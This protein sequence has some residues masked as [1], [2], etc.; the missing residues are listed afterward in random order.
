MTTF[1]VL[2]LRSGDTEARVV[3]ARGGL[4]TALRVGARDVLYLD[5]AT[6]LDPTKNVRG[7]APL[8]FPSPGRLTADRY[9]HAGASYALGQHG[10]ARST[11]FDVLDV[12]PDAARM[13]LG[14]SGATREVYPFEFA[15]SVDVR[16]SAGALRVDAEVSNR[17][18]AVMPY[19]F[20]THPYF[21]VPVA[22][23]ALARLPTRATRAWDNVTKQTRELPVVA[24]D[25]G[26]VDLHLLGH[27]ASSAEL[28][29]PDGRV[30][31]GG[32]DGWRRWVVW[33]LPGRD[34]VCVE[35]WTSPAD[36]LNTGDDLLHLAPG[37]SRA[38]RLSISW[39]P[40]ASAA[41]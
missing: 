35:P 24:L 8:L 10:F 27:G 13:R 25:A 16:V 2:T 15:L 22:Q 23:K 20:G 17:G 1:E 9:T 37:E 3:P 5:E 6:L 21:F 4:V 32:D 14:A 29:L 26:E 7:G 31:L 11:P 38:H 12:R 36:A 33:T 41:R 39:E 30:V 40:A 18:D 34:F 19:G 28:S